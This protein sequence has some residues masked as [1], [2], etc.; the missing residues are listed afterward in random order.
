MSGAGP[1]RTYLRVMEVP[2]DVIELL[3]DDHREVNQLFGRFK[4]S[5]KAD[6]RQNLIKKIVRELSV[7]A[8][9]EEQFVYPVLRAK[10]D[11]GSDLADHAI[12]E[13]QEVKRLLADIEK[14]DAASSELPRKLDQLAEAVHEHVAE[15]ERDVLPRLAEATGPEFRDKLGSVVEKAKLAVPT[16]P[17]PL[18]PGTAT[19]Q[20]LAG[21]WASLV[22]H[23]RD[24]V[25]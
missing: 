10:I 8:A 24:L 13:H 22:D 17:H 4:R 19:A 5:S 9:V 20:L 21:P 15:E 3:T 16:H 12:Q 6:T 18:V 11:D 1:A 25:A 14:L 23:L 7:H 2:M